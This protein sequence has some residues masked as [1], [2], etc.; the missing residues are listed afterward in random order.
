MLKALK[1]TPLVLGFSLLLSACADPKANY[2]TEKMTAIKTIAVAL[3]PK[4]YYIASTPDGL[5]MIGG[6]AGLVADGIASI[7][8]ADRVKK[9]AAFND[10]VTAQLGDTALNRKFA[11]AVE[12]E[13]TAQGYTV[14]EVDLSKDGMPKVVYDDR[15]IWS[16]KG[17]AYS[18][19]DAILVVQVNTAYFA[20]GTIY[21]YNREVLGDIKIFKSD[22]LEPAFQERLFFVKLSD[23]YSYSTYADLVKD[24]PHAI[25]GLNQATMSF[26]PE[27]AANL[28][29]SRQVTQTTSQPADGKTL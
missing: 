25:D 22:T 8:S 21:P 19:A 20:Q 16:L 14:T 11:D 10:L 4:T 29:A 3:P 26:I 23:K 24:L 5:S 6:I 17:S 9:R 27:F 7:N 18:G 13:L 28:K 15:R 12:A 2:S 1:R